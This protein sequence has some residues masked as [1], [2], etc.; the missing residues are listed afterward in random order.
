MVKFTIDQIRAI[1]DKPQNIRNISIIAHVD[2]G[3]SSLTDSLVGAAGIIAEGNVGKARHT[4]T[5][6]DE[7]ERCITI[8][9][10][11]ISMYYELEENQ[12]SNGFLVNLIDSPGHIDFSSEVTAALRVTDGAIVVVDCVEGVCVQTRTVLQQS[13]AE[14]VKPVLM[15]NKMDRIFLELQLSPEEAYK[16]FLRT[17]EEANVLISTYQDEN[18]MGDLQVHPSEGTI[19]FGSGLH[20][21]AF[22][23]SDFVEMQSKNKPLDQEGKARLSRHLWGDHF[24]EETTKKWYTTPIHEGKQLERG[25][26]RFVLKPIYTLFDTIVQQQDQDK[27]LNMIQKLGIKLTNEELDLR[28]K[29]LFKVVMRRWLPASDALLGMISQKL[30]SPVEAQQYRVETLYEGD[31]NDECGQ[32]IKHCDP[33][34]PLMLYVSKMVPAKEDGRFYAF[35]RVFS[36]RAQTGAK[37]RIMGP[38]YKPGRKTDLFLGSIHRTLIMM[39]R[40]VESVE[41]IPAGNTC[42]LVG[43]DQYLLKSGTI[44]TSELAH[45]IRP[46]KFSVSPVVRIAVNPKRDID[47]PKFHEGL[48]KLSKSDPMVQVQIEGETILWG[49]GELHLEICVNDL[50]EVYCG[51]MELEVSQPV[52]TYAETVIGVANQDPTVVLSK[53]P[54][55]HNRLYMSAEP[56]AT[57]MIS[58]I[59]E[60]G[61]SEMSENESESIV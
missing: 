18:A 17:I 45:N 51:G 4:D 53:S 59:E 54:N 46:M 6:K 30:P 24:Y 58:M 55:K 40:Y 20:G 11:G 22:R 42:G 37:V 47:L 38:N 52:V 61:L 60:G 35:G 21:W 12:S 5:R 43:I 9:S 29:E 36:G 3:K 28:G 1:M 49:V 41:D 31:L 50:S 13:L 27:T 15:I 16:G 56:L 34:G 25:F 14:R 8:K 23:L 48:K 19:A 57:E 10:T 2:H 39:G 26:C 33:N 44:T 7:Q 32:A